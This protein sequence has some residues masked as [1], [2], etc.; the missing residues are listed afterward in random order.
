LATLGTMIRGTDLIFGLSILCLTLPPVASG[1]TVASPSISVA[2][3]TAPIKLDGLLNEPAWLEATTIAEL[4]QQS[5]RPGAPTPYRTTV[6][7]IIQDNRLYFGFECTDP[8]PGSIA[9]HTMRRDGPMDGDDT[10]SIV[11]DTSGDKRTGYFFRVNEAGARVD[12]LIAGREEAKLDWDG[13]WDARTSRT[14]TGWSAELEIPAN[15]L[16]FK[17]GLETWGVNFERRIARDHTAMRWASPVLD[18]FFFDLSR[19]GFL[20]N[21]MGLDQGRGIEL[22]PFFAGRAQTNFHQPAYTWQ[23]QVGGDTTWRITPQL[24]SVFTF[25]TD[26]AEAEVDSLQLNVTRFPLFYPEKRPFFLEGANQF[27]FAFALEDDFIPFFSRNIGL[28]QGDQIPID[29]GGKLTGRAGKWNIG[30]LDVETRKTF[31][32]SAVS[33]VPGTNLFAARISYDLTPKLRVGS[34]LTNGNPD[35]VHRNTLVGFDSSWRTSE[36]FGTKNF[37]VAGWTAFSRGDGLRGDRNGWGYIVDYPNDFLDCFTALNHFGEALNPGLGFLPRPGIRKLDAACRVKPRPSKEGRLRRVRQAALEHRYYRV[38]NWHGQTESWGLTWSPL[39]ITLESG[40]RFDFA[41]QPQFEF[42]PVPFQISPGVTLPGGSYRFDR[43]R[44]EFQS[45]D[46]RPWGF[47]STTWFG[48]FYDGR[49][50]QQSD[51]LRFTGHAG[52]WQ[53]GASIDQNFAALREGDFVQRLAQFNLAYALHPNLILTSFFQYDTQAQS[54]GNNLRLRWTVRPGNDLFIIWNR[55]WHRL[56]LT[57]NDVNIVHA[58]D[59]LTVKLRWTFRQ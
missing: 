12:G 38:T 30:L 10:V 47:G 58:K 25:N 40:D 46:H 17:R 35:G 56:T 22:S 9:V 23:G 51:Y 44:A 43:F 11:L 59:S 31:S 55:N 42:L 19:A 41:L 28:F 36:L 5:P 24:A 21:V 3:P 34:I 39:N 27:E 8:E 52:H 50:L 15:T 53:A 2:F 6:R 57:P 20:R 13:V 54:I 32:P 16:S 29:G 48:S 37:Q 18:T 14:E 1:Q 45:S 4:V 49:L 7:V 33:V 26:F